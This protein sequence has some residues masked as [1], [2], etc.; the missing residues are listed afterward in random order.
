MAE[1]KEEVVILIDRGLL[2]GSAYVNTSQ[3]NAV[4]EDLSLHSEILRDTRYD[5]IIHMVTAADGAEQFYG[6]QITETLYESAEEAREKDGTLRQA[7]MGHQN[8]IL[9]KNTECRDFDDKIDKTKESV[10]NV[11]GKSA[12]TTFHKKFLLK[13]EKM[14]DVA[15]MPLGLGKPNLKNMSQSFEEIQITEIF[16]D[17]KHFEG[18]EVLECSVQKKGSQSRFSYTHKLTI[19][20]NGQKLEKKRVIS[21]AEYLNYQSRMKKDT[22][23]LRS[24]RLCIIDDG[25][26]IIVNYFIEKDGAPLLAIVQTRHGASQ[27]DLKLPDYIK[28]FR[29]VTDEP[30]YLASSMSLESYKMPEADKKATN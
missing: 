7:Y 20:K 27:M 15:V 6:Q 13:K 22:K 28:V 24:K 30:Q 26:Y 25:V 11:L 17:E 29:E 8:W 1:T 12:G 10:L 4:L 2:D 23:P 16:I 9:I 21:A 14:Q 18:D 5:A 3:W 19:L